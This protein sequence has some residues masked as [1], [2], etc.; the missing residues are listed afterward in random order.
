MV[1]FFLFAVFC[2]EGVNT[3]EETWLSEKSNVVAFIFRNVYKD[4]KCLELACSSQEELDSW[5]ASLLQAG[6]Y[7]EKVT[8]STLTLF[9]NQTLT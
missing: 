7:P 9:I 3:G 8:V 6:V 5:K 1:F 2:E 4:Y